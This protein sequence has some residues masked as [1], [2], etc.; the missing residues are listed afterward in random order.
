[1]L[2]FFSLLGQPE[3]FGR[4]SDPIDDFPWKLS[5]MNDKKGQKEKGKK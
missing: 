5:L 4:F 2:V 1:M 3:H